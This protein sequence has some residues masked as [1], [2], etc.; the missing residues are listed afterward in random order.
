M[1]QLREISVLQLPVPQAGRAYDIW[2]YY[3]TDT[4]LAIPMAPGT[5]CSIFIIPVPRDG[6][7]KIEIAAGAG[8]P[9][10]YNYVKGF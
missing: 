1:V 8:I 9:F 2:G 6:Y 4:T 7:R 3:I 10:S 5:R